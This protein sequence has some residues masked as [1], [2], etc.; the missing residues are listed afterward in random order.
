MLRATYVANVNKMKVQFPNA[1]YIAVTRG[2]PR[3]KYSLWI[4]DLAPSEQLKYGYKNGIITWEEY[5]LRFT[6]EM[7]SDNAQRAL[8]NVRELVTGSDVFLVCFEKDPSKCHR[9]I[10]INMINN[11]P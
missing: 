5:V 11:L 7:K 8:N 2:R 6:E 1:V 9:S 10:L 3:F 4:K